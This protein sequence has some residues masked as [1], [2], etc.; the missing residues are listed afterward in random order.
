MKSCTHRKLEA[1]KDWPEF[2]RCVL[3]GEFIPKNSVRV[4]QRAGKDKP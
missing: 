2:Y 3:C 1:P 4:E